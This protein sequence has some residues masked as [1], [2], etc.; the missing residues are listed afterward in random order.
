[1]HLVKS[2]IWLNYTYNWLILSNILSKLNYILT[3][4]INFC[5][6]FSILTI[7]HIRIWWRFFQNLLLDFAVLYT[8]DCSLF[9]KNDCYS[10]TTRLF[11]NNS[12]RNVCYFRI[13]KLLKEAALKVYV[14]LKQ[15]DFWMKKLWKCMLFQ[16]NKISEWRSSESICCSWTTR[17]YQSCYSC[18]FHYYHNKFLWSD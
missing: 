16:D 10:E 9:L 18:M 6:N 15:Q 7:N 13:T 12:C 14:I 2:I 17:F 3:D 11:Q 1:M 4:K 8:W 5:D